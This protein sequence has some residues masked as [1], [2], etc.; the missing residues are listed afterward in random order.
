MV[1]IS[2]A[3][4]EIL[5]NF[6]NIVLNDNISL[7]TIIKECKRISPLIDD[8]YFPYIYS[9]TLLAAEGKVD[10]AIHLYSFCPNNSFAQIVKKYLEEYGCLTPKIKV[11]KD[12]APYTAWTKT[13]FAKNYIKKTVDIIVNFYL[14][15]FTAK[16]NEINSTIINKDRIAVFTMILAG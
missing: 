1:S 10:K 4:V 13:D 15:K 14:K 16:E 2:L 3:E 5:N 11:F 6:K 8:I 7:E 9:A 12:N